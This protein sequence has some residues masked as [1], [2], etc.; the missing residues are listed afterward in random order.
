MI[1]LCVAWMDCVW[2]KDYELLYLGA[3]ALDAVGI[4][5]TFSF[6]MK[7]YSC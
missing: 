1:T 2:N 5:K 4:E 6:V 7:L 3:V